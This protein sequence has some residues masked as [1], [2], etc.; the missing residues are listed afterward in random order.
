ML[1]NEYHNMNI[2]LYLI[3][4]SPYPF[5]KEFMT[6]CHLFSERDKIFR[7]TILTQ[8][9]SFVLFL[10]NTNIELVTFSK[11][12]VNSKSNFG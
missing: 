10:S 11:G 2:P 7:G 3:F 6:F 5:M 1:I 9:H 4:T 8:V 12:L